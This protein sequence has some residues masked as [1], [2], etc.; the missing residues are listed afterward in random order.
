MRSQ[1][2]GEFQERE[3][4][5]IDNMKHDIYYFSIDLNLQEEKKSIRIQ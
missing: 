3:E 5:G 4:G 1:T 2:L